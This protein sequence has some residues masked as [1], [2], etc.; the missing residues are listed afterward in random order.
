M[1]GDTVDLVVGSKFL[2]DG[3]GIPI[4]LESRR[5][6]RLVEWNKYGNAEVLWPNG[7]QFSY[8]AALLSKRM[9]KE[10]GDAES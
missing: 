5:G 1:V 2:P 9:S 10:P 6:G 4:E 3:R 8:E 7:E